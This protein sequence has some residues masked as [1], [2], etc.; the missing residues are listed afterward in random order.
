MRVTGGCFCGAVRYQSKGAP[1]S[2]L[3]CH[4]ETCRE[5]SSAPFVAWV[6]FRRSDFEFTTGAPAEL[7]SSANVV[8]TYCTQCGT[9][10]GYTNMRS[11]DEIDITTCSLDDPNASPPTRHEWVSEALPWI[12]MCDGLPLYPQS[13]SQAQSRSAH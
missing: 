3:I 11:L 13:K 4:C 2:S 12:K 7:H 10:L 9:A 6:T 5:V 1:I 8:R